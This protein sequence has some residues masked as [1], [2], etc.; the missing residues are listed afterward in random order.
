VTTDLTA[1]SVTLHPCTALAVWGGG[2]WADQSEV[3]APL[4]TALYLQ[5]RHVWGET[6]L[7]FQQYYQFFFNNIIFENSC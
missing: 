4:C 5:Y 1:D 6:V 2:A 3:T 7:I